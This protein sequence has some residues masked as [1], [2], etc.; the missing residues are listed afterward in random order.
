[1]QIMQMDQICGALYAEDLS[2]ATLF[3]PEISPLGSIRPE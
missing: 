3:G 2:L 1:M